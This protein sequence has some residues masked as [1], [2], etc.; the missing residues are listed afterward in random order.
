MKNPELLSRLQAS[1]IGSDTQYPTVDGKRGPRTYL[2]SAASTLM[3][4]PAFN[5]GHQFL[6][7]YAST[8]SDMHYS[9]KGATKAFAWAHK[10]VLEFVGASEEKYCAFFAGSG[11]TAGFNRM[12][13]SLSKIRPER[14]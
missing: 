13:T 8:H 14:D 4:K 7:H 11:S 3:M 12:A 6:T 9:A 2:D 5:V 10:R 1:F